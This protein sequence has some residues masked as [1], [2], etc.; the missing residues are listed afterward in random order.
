MTLRTASDHRFLAWSPVFV[1]LSGSIVLICVSYVLSAEMGP[2]A[3]RGPGVVRSVSAQAVGGLCFFM[4]VNCTEGRGQVL[5]G[6][7][8]GVKQEVRFD[9]GAR[10]FH[11]TQTD[12]V[13]CE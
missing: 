7:E 6:K 2:A 12:G 1:R 8:R 4:C 13:R 10:R 5:F 3:P 11:S 9:V